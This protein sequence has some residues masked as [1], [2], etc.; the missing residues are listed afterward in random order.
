MC[1]VSC[2]RCN[3]SAVTCHMSLTPTATATAMAPL[4]A[5]SPT[6]QSRMLL[7][8]LTKIHQEW[9]AKKKRNLSFS[10]WQFSTILICLLYCWVICQHTRERSPSISGV[11]LLAYQGFICQG[12]T[13]ILFFTESA[14]CAYSVSK[15]QWTPVVRYM[16]HFLCFS[17]NILLLPFTKVKIPINQQQKDFLEKNLDRKLS[18]IQQFCL[19]NG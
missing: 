19:R 12:S 4:P 13:N 17:L 7:L 14:N 8:I 10:F 3:M 5:N 9:V 11:D 18:Q 1:R 6:I 2:V 15:L 16:C